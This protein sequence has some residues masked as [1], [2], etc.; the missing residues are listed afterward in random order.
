MDFVHIIQLPGPSFFINDKEEDLALEKYIG[1][2][3]GVQA[4]TACKKVN[5]ADTED[6]LFR[7][8]RM[9]GHCALALT[10]R[11]AWKPS[12]NETLATAAHCILSWQ[13]PFSAPG[14]D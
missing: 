1:D 4:L 8:V 2:I 6:N 14:T 11:Y 7:L 13:G 12:L 5:T 10:K 3:F 9:S